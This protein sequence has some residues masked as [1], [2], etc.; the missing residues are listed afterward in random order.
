M[1]YLVK[2]IILCLKQFKK[3]STK[4]ISKKINNILYDLWLVTDSN[5]YKNISL[6]YPNWKN[7]NKTI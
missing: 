2:K 5:K 6:F 3:I 7:N 1:V 4:K